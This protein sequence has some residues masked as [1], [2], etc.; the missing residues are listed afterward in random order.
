MA[1]VRDGPGAGSSSSSGS[2][3]SRIQSSPSLLLATS[4]AASFLIL[5]VL[6]PHSTRAF[7]TR[8]L[9]GSNPSGDDDSSSNGNGNGNGNGSASSRKS[10]NGKG[11]NARI[12]QP[13][14]GYPSSSS[15]PVPP[16]AQLQQ[17]A[18]PSHRP[19]GSNNCCAVFWDVDNCSPPTGM[20]GRD[21]ALAI[22]KAIQD[23]VVPGTSEPI[24]VFKAYLELSSE[25]VSSPAQV[26]LRSELQG[27]GVSLLDTPKS[28]YKQVADQMMITDLLAFAIDHPA[29][30]R[31]VLI[32]GDRDFAYPIGTLRNRGFLITL[33][34]PPAHV[35]P[36]LEASAQVVLRWRQDVLGINHDKDGKPYTGTRAVKPGTTL[37]S[38]TPTPSHTTLSRS[39]SKSTADLST[40]A[41]SAVTTTTPRKPNPNQAASAN[42]KP[43]PA[44]FK[45]LVDLLEGMRKQGISRPLRS[46]VAAQLRQVDKDLFEKAGASRWAEYAAVAE[47]AG[48]ITLGGT[49]VSGHEWVSLA[50]AE[51]GGAG[52]T[53]PASP[54]AARSKAA[55]LFGS[56]SSYSNKSGPPQTPTKSVTSSSSAS[57]IYQSAIAPSASTSSSSNTRLDTPELRPFLPLIEMLNSQRS[58]GIVLPK[59]S[60]ISNHFNRMVSQGVLDPDPYRQAGVSTFAQYIAAAERSGVAR[61]QGDSVK[62]HPRYAGVQTNVVTPSIGRMEDTAYVPPLTSGANKTGAAGALQ[63]AN[64]LATTIKAKVASTFGSSSS[65]P[66]EEQTRRA[67]YQ[68]LIECLREQ[69]AEKHF[70]SADFFI[71]LVLARL[72]GGEHLGRNVDLFNVFLDQAERDGVVL[73]EPGFGHGRRHVRLAP[74]WVGGEEVEEQDVVVEEQEEEEEPEKEQEKEK[75]KDDESSVTSL[76]PPSLLSKMLPAQEAI[77]AAIATVLGTNG[78]EDSDSGAGETPQAASSSSEKNATGTTPVGN[79]GQAAEQRARY[80]PLVDALIRL[81][82]EYQIVYPSMEQ[83]HAELRERSSSSNVLGEAATGPHSIEF[84]QWLSG[85][86]DLGLVVIERYEEGAGGGVGKARLRLADRYVE[87]FKL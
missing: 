18:P 53:A 60:Y 86:A 71:Q 29:P 55:S 77:K 63:K 20:S 52:Q 46:G 72:P 62:L 66:S 83:L 6:F 59:L 42:G 54:S 41:S 38:T 81:R 13:D 2:L 84:V 51:D 80:K 74:A 8:L 14:T 45:P 64:T 16:P 82:R 3:I 9:P 4:S 43:V 5:Y 79:N 50:G 65:K 76:I 57:A 33:I 35:A 15:S 19:H 56:G 31:I 67:L 48:I 23:L 39:Q 85:A 75:E 17:H 44:V 24:I 37:A 70:Y 27:S 11:K 69:R 78:T 34:T 28:G 61:A 25:N 22:R 30:A 26:A 73:L 40:A 36:I 1:R 47:A 12:A 87:M 10:K 7:F 49:G 58:I 32:S 68:G 21:V